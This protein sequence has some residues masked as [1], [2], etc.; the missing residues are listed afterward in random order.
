MKKTKLTRSLL[1]ACSIVALSAVMYGCVHGG[2]DPAPID[3]TDMEMPEPM[4]EPTPDPGP[5]DLEETQTAAADAAAAAMTASDN[6]AA[7]ASSAAAATMN[8]ATLQ[9]GADSN[10][11]AMGGREAATAASE[12]ADDAADAASEAADASAAAAA[13]TTGD[14]AED[15]WS[16]AVAARDAAEA[17]EATAATMAE[18]AIAAAMTEL[19]ID[20]TMKSAGESSIDTEMD[21]LTVTAADGSKT[22][23]GY[24]SDLMRENSGG[25]VG[26]PGR[27]AV[28]ARDLAIGKTLDTTD[29]KARV[30][31]IHSRESSK[32]VRVYAEE[33]DDPGDLSIRT[34]ITGDRYEI[35]EDDP[36]DVDTP[37]APTL[38]S[39]GMYYEATAAEDEVAG[40]N[41]E[42]S[43]VTDIRVENM[44][45]YTDM[46]GAKTKGKEVFFYVDV[47][48]QG[49]ED[50]A[51]D[52]STTRYVI[53]QD[54]DD[55]VGDNSHT[56]YQ[57][58]DPGQVPAVIPM[59]IEY[60]HIHFGVWA[61]LGDAEKDG[62]QKLADLGIGFVQSIGDGMTER[63]GIGTVSYYG[64]WVA[65]IQGQISPGEGAFNMDDGPATLTADFD[66]DKFEADLDGLA[67]LEGTLD[68]NG[69]SG[70][71]AK[72]ITHADLD[73]SGDF[74]GEFSGNIYG[75]KG[76]E[77]AGV[78][79]FA[80]DEAGSFRG[81]FGGTN[82]K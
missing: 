23:T 7:S 24:Q 29:D 26:Q 19:H 28:E 4:P 37:E 3:E 51:D 74:A 69:F 66:K 53:V 71:T 20:G 39:L 81:A 11:D 32:K 18:A 73:G 77:A 61:T 16:D 54:T 72:G 63:L 34:T 33:A 67:T 35:A 38:K 52:V 78:F 75:D 6:A 50:P 57:H 15:A 14:A 64:D 8:L 9:T 22:I 31:V 21:M 62:S 59:A 13:A 30:T 82:Q 47:A 12:A 55:I 42:G 79:D 27:Q 80:G 5:T 1:A 60:D 65:V 46:V 76:E 41:A 56:N 44:L 2:D 68:G 25:M 43:T 48:D 40:V 49:N 17:A 58:V 45:D 70:M 36:V 10:S